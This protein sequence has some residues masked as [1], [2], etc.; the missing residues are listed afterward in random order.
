MIPLSILFIMLVVDVVI[1]NKFFVNSVVISKAK[2]DEISDTLIDSFQ[3]NLELL[4][5]SAKKSCIKKS[6]G[7]MGNESQILRQFHDSIR[8]RVVTVVGVHRLL[9]TISLTRAAI[10]LTPKGLMI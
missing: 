10:I 4:N 5:P 3:S 7:H 9:A 1:L 8:T 6:F 2:T